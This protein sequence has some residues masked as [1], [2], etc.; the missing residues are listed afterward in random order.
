MAQMRRG[1]RG[2]GVASLAAPVQQPTDE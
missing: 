1:A 2:R